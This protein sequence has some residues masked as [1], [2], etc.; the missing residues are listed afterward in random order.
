MIYFIYHFAPDRA[1]QFEN[2]LV[3]HE[4]AKQQRVDPAAVSSFQVEQAA[5]K[6]TKIDGEK[7]HR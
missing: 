4:I 2:V 6:T 3:K 1:I 7:K 5:Q